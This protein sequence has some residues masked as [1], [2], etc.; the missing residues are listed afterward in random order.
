MKTI[1]TTLL[2]LLGLGT[3]SQTCEVGLM[4]NGELTYFE[5][6]CNNKEHAIDSIK[7]ANYNWHKKHINSIQSAYGS[8]PFFIHYFDIS[9]Y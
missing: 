7:I 6:D 3:Y 5:Y 8:S 9:R 1:I 4:V 2:F